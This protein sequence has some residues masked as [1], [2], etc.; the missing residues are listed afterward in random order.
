M[1]HYGNEEAVRTWLAAFDDD[2]Q[3]TPE[4]LDEALSAADDFINEKVDEK[5]IPTP[6][7]QLLVRAANYWAKMEILD[8]FYNT[9][10]HRSPTAAK[11]EERALTRREQY[12]KEN[13]TQVEEKRYSHSHTPGD[14]MFRES[15]SGYVDPDRW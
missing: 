2:E 15:D 3:L 6:T 11:Y 8:A 9:E 5:S 12:L 10:E 13:P 4:L 7:P 14:P 1:A